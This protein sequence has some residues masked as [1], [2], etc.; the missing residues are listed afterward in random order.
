MLF[1]E[2]WLGITSLCIAFGLTVGL[3]A[4]PHRHHHHRMHHG[5]AMMFDRGFQ[6][7]DYVRPPIQV[8]APVEI[9]PANPAEV[10]ARANV[11]HCMT[12]SANIDLLIDI[13]RDG[14]VT[15]V[16]NRPSKETDES[17]CIADELYKL[18]FADGEPT[19]IRYMFSKP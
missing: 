10:I 7:S 17:R 14:H 5:H 2:R 13:G 9:P 11:Q 12:T 3:V 1:A 6:C 15:R 8:V 18:H 4:R 19:T 16:S